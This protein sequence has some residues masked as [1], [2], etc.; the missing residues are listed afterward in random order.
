[1]R[2]AGNETGANMNA[3]AIDLDPSGAV[4]LS[5]SG[6][7]EPRAAVAA[8]V[9]L[10]VQLIDYWREQLAR[11]VAARR[12]DLDVV[13]ARIRSG[14]AAAPALLPFALGDTDREVVFRATVGYVGG[15]S[16][17]D[18]TSPAA[19]E[20]AVEWVRRGLA[21]NRAAVFAALLSLGDERVIEQ[22]R[23]LRLVLSDAEIDAVRTGLDAD[24][25]VPTQEFMHSWNELRGL[26]LR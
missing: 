22:L 14:A 8:R 13:L 26:P 21:L 12:R 5:P 2:P 18:A 24:L 3:V 6:Q 17:H 15:P 20:D 4:T 25:P 23:P 7:T 16:A 10:S 1:M 9:P 19:A 11:P